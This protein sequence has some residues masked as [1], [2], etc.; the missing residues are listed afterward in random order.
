MVP[1]TVTHGS[2]PRRKPGFRKNILLDC[3]FRRNDDFNDGA[4]RQK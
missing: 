4:R 2:S 3:G 1:G